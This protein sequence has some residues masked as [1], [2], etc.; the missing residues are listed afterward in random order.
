MIFIII[1]LKHRKRRHIE[2]LCPAVVIKFKPVEVSTGFASRDNITTAT[3]EV[4]KMTEQGCSAIVLD[5]FGNSSVR[6]AQFDGTTAL[7]FKSG[8]RFHL[9]GDVVASPVPVFRNIVKATVPIFMAAG[10]TPCIVV[11]PLPRYIFAS[12]CNDPSHCPNL[13]NPNHKEKMLTDFIQL[14]HTLVKELVANGVSNFKV[15]DTC[16][17]TAL[18]C[19]ANTASRIQALAEI[20]ARDGVHLKP[21]GYFNLARSIGTGMDSLAAPKRNPKKQKQ[22]FWRGF[23]STKGSD[24]MAVPHGTTN[25]AT[26]HGKHHRGRSIHGGNYMFHPYKR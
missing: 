13:S 5:L 21:E 8:G 20:T 15:L 16:S 3:A 2:R 9:N 18:P 22:Y 26:V 7:P 4:R 17:A 24:T 19:T 14:R 6:F 1:D 25:R 10:K 11:P 12:C 23:K